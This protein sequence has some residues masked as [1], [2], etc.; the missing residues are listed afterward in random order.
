VGETVPYDGIAGTMREAC[1][2]DFI[3]GKL[4]ALRVR[5]STF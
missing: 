3:A 1:C 5:I 2:R 4:A